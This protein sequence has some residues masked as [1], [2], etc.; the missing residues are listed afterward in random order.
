MESGLQAK[1]DITIDCPRSAI[2]HSTEIDV[3]RPVIIKPDSSRE[4]STFSRG[5]GL[6]RE[7]L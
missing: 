3:G 7:I 5:D 6:K 4:Y 1:Y 2:L